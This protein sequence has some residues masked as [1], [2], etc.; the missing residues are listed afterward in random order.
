MIRACRM[1]SATTNAY[2]ILIGKPEGR[3]PGGPMI[4]KWM[5]DRIGRYEMD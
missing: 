5:R 4:L 1:N 3:I 2:M